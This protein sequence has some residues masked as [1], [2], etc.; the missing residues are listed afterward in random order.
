MKEGQNVWGP[1]SEK[2]GWSSLRYQVVKLEHQCRSRIVAWKDLLG[3]GSSEML[4]GR[5]G[6]RSYDSRRSVLMEL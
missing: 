1:V 6:L 4:T 2:R 3:R 5:D